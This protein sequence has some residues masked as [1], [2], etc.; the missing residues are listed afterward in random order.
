MAQLRFNEAKAT[1]VACL[2][3]RL[4]GETMHYFKLIKL[5]YIIDRTALQRWGRP[6][7]TDHHVSMDKGPVVSRIYNLISE[8]PGPESQEY[9]HTYISDPH[10]DRQVTCLGDP[11]IN[12]LSEMEVGLVEEV[13]KEHGYKNRWRIRDET[14][15]FGEWRDPDGSMIPITYEDILKA[16]GKT[17]EEVQEIR[18]E[19]ESV[20]RAD[21]MLS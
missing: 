11:G 8:G 1:Q 12:E 4:R 6:V 21:A 3:L 14:H 2:L 20:A 15:K 16:G 10:G 9:W 13:F 5:L 19:I 18:E 7:T 17:P